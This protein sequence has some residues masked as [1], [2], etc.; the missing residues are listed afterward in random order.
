MKINEI[1]G[2]VPLFDLYQSLL[3]DK[4]REYFIM[5]YYNDFSLGEIASNLGISRNA[6][7]DII[8]KTEALLNDYES[9]LH[10]N[11][12]RLKREEIYDSLD[13]NIALK[14]RK[15]EEI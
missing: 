9:K 14:L 13:E 3:T 15:I 10:L 12:K 4:Q 2:L 1:E 6:V 5:Y 11:E 7:F 8:K